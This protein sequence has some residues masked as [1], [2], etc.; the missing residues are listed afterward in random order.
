MRF[1]VSSPFSA[2]FVGRFLDRSHERSVLLCLTKG[3][4]SQIFVFLK[5]HFLGLVVEIGFVT[6][7]AFKSEMKFASRDN[8]RKYV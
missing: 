7:E 6:A 5:A 8:Y 1:V 2:I 3:M 4:D